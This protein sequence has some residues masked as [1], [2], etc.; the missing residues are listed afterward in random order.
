MIEHKDTSYLPFYRPSLLE[1]PK[2]KH[3]YFEL[4]DL[5]T[6]IQR[7]NNPHYWLQQDLLQPKQF[8]YKFFQIIVL[9]ADTIPQMKVFSQF[10]F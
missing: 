1:S 5:E 3:E 4:P 10:F 8:Q 7:H 6:K 9:H 2:E